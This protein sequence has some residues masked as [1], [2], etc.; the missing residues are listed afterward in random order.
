[1]LQQDEERKQKRKEAKERAAAFE[2]E[3]EHALDTVLARKY[4]EGLLEL[5]Y[6]DEAEVSK[7]NRRLKAAQDQTR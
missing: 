4:Q 5:G 1:M 6:L 2:Y 3:R 7:M